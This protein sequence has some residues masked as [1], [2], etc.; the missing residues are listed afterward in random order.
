LLFDLTKNL[1]F[2]RPRLGLVLG[3]VCG[4]CWRLLALMVCCFLSLW[5]LAGNSKRVNDE[6]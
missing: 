2:M 1:T 5:L 6:K 3:F 4:C